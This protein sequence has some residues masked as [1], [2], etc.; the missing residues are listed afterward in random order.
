MLACLLICFNCIRFFVTLWTIAYQ[1][2]LLT[3]FSKQEYW[4]GLHTLLQ[5]ISLTQ[6]LHLHLLCFL[7][8]Q[9][10]TLSLG[11][12]FCHSY[13]LS[14]SHV[15]MWPLDHKSWT[16]KN[17]CLWT[18]MLKKT[19]ESPLDCKETKPVNPKGNQW[20]FIGSTDAEAEVPIFWSPPIGADL[21]EKSLMLRK[22]EARRKRGQKKM[23]CL[24]GI[25]DSMDKKTQ[26]NCEGQGSQACCSPLGWK[27]SD[28]I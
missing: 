9:A 10:D 11:P 3:G 2:P 13:G 21:L 18:V 26:G 12:F 14:S 24:D 19:L 17:R 5:G 27:E 15:W 28:M 20:I 25:T 8:C 6:G 1:V 7:S 16:L 22:T 4:S 23:R